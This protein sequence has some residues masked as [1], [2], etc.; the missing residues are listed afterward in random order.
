MVKHNN[1]RYTILSIIQQNPKKKKNSLSTC[2][3][4]RNKQSIDIYALLFINTINVNK[5]VQ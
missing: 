1:Y 3:V 5:I 4:I 2:K